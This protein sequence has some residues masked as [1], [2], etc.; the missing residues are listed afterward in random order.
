MV[1]DG[2]LGEGS[3]LAVRFSVG[4]GANPA[5][6]TQPASGESTRGVFLAGLDAEDRICWLR[7]FGSV[8]PGPD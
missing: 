1:V 6:P 5:R 7:R 8:G 2:V 4:P 3:T